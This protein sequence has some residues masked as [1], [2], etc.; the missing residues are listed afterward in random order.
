MQSTTRP[1]TW[2]AAVRIPGFRKGKVPLPVLISRIGRERLYAEAVES[3]IGG[4]FRNAAAETKIRPVEQPE[5]G[6]ELPE[7]PDDAWRFT[8][9]VG[10]QAEAVPV[11]WTTLQ[12]GAHEPVVPAEAIDAEIDELRRTVAELVPVEGRPARTGDTVVIDVVSPSGEAQRDVVAELGGERLVEEIESALEGMQAG[13]TATVTYELADESMPTVEVTLKDI[14]EAVLPPVDDE[15]ARAATEFDTIAELRA[16]IEARLREQLTDELEARFRTDALDALVAASN[17]EVAP[18]LVDGRAAELWHGLVHS[19]ERRGL[20]PEIY[21]QLTGQ[22]PEEVTERLRAEARQSI[23]RELV[24]EAAA[25][26]VGLEVPDAEVEALVREQAGEEGEDADT[27]IAQLREGGRW[28]RLRADM[29]L[30][31]ALDRVVAEVERIPAD[32]AAAREKLWTPEQE[33]PETPTK[34]W[35]PG[36][37]EP[38]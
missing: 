6:Y 13:E 24:L 37:K 21:L 35:T 33:T 8:A 12:V 36:S 1:P 31:N 15:L 11:D 16:D 4:W 19:L 27:V 5:Y 28:E 14:K 32:L 29:R 22:T 25:D 7:S 9:T 3:H 30:R 2:Q 10:V 26:R 20:Q 18:G 38:A 34:L 17:V 23:A